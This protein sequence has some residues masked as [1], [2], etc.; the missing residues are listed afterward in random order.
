MNGWFF[1]AE[2]K[3]ASPMVSII[4]QTEEEAITAF[5]HLDFASASAIRV[6]LY[7]MEAGVSNDVRVL[8]KRIIP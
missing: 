3:Y 1:I 6:T 7:K 8:W 2:Y 5:T 4:R